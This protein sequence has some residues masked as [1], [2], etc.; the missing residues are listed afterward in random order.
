MVKAFIFCRVCASIVV[1]LPMKWVPDHYKC[2]HC[3]VESTV[4]WRK[5]KWDG[6]LKGLTMFT[7]VSTQSNIAYRM[8]LMNVNL[9]YCASTLPKS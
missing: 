7:A 9:I 8:R 3:G 1:E 4:R 6:T 2:P 5:K